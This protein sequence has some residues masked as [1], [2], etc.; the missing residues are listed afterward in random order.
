MLSEKLNNAT[1]AAAVRVQTE[2]AVLK[3]KAQTAVEEK[4][5]GFWWFVLAVVLIIAGF[6]MFWCMTNWCKNNGHGDFTGEYS[7]HGWYYDVK[8][9]W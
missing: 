9:S 5:F 6:A 8:C 1:I 4:E 3:S 7:D 2:A